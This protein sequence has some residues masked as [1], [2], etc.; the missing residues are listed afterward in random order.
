MYYMKDRNKIEKARE[1]L[2]YIKKK[3]NL[4]TDELK[5]L[6]EEVSFP[7]EIFN[8]KITVLESVVKYLREEKNFSLHNISNFLK[9]DERNIWGIYNKSSKKYPKRFIV[10]ESEFEI[11]ISIFDS[12][13]SALESLAVYL[14]DKLNLKFSQI[15][16]LLHRDQRTIWTSYSRAKEKYAKQR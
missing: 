16:I 2:L 3:Y 15:A 11:P 1:L 7:A 4:T 13:L 10:K 12:K 6:I 5:N 14:H 9:R 8:D